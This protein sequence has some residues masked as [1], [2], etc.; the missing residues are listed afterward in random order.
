MM[1]MRYELRLSEWKWPFY[2]MLHP[3]TGYE[4]LRWKKAY[5]L[6]TAWAAVAAFFIISVADAQLTG[7]LFN[8]TYTKVFNIVPHFSST[9][10]LFI[11][12]VIANRSLC[13]LFDGEG[14]VKSIFCASAYALVPYLISGIAVIAA[15]NVLLM[16]ESGFITL[17]RCIGTGW[18]VILMISAIKTVNQYSLP[19]TIAVMILTVA[20]MALILFLALLL[21]VLFQQVFVFVYSVIT[22]IIYRISY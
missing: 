8:Y 19:R 21:I 1:S 22:E 10:I 2:I 11:T 4:D 17:L 9:V 12:W 5:S 20:A 6:K 3:F 15:S 13:T 18:S 7:F 14:S 16:N